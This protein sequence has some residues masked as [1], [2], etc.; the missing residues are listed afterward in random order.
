VNPDTDDLPWGD[1]GEWPW[2]DDGQ[3]VGPLLPLKPRLVRDRKAL[4]DLLANLRKVGCDLRDAV[5]TY[6]VERRSEA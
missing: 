5:R 6:R 2:D 1:G 4:L 3:W